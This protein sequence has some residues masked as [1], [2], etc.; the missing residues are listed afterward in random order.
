MHLQLGELP[1]SVL[2]VPSC[3]AYVHQWTYQLVGEDGAASFLV[4][5]K[6]TVAWDAEEDVAVAV[7]VPVY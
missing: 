5:D 4:V 2:E 3:S 7:A 6:Q 1:S